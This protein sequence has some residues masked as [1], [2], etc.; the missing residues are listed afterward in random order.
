MTNNLARA[1]AR[2]LVWAKQFYE[3]PQEEKILK[4]AE[5]I[6]NAVVLDP[7][8][9]PNGQPDFSELPDIDHNYKVGN[10]KARYIQAATS[11]YSRLMWKPEEDCES[12]D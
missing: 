1:R 6:Y 3:L 11:A 10:D 8:G 7:M 12:N 2:G 9:Y 5:I 4:I